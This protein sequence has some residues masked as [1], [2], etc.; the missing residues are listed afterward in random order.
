MVFESSWKGPNADKSTLGSREEICGALFVKED[1]LTPLHAFACFG[2]L[3][4][5]SEFLCGEA[6]SK[7]RKVKSLAPED[8]DT[9]G[10][11]SFRRAPCV[12]IPGLV[13]GSVLLRED[14]AL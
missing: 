10:A 14:S 12:P 3:V 2:S 7:I 9:P 11:R 5:L 4:S 6:E 1:F 13:P 8:S